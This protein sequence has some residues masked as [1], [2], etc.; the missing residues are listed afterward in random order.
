MKSV[1]T[2]RV[3]LVFSD[4]SQ[5]T[6]T[7]KNGKL[8]SKQRQRLSAKEEAGLTLVN[9][10]R[11]ENMQEINELATEMGLPVVF[12]A[13]EAAQENVIGKIGLFRWKRSGNVVLNHIV[14][15]TSKTYMTRPYGSDEV[16]CP[17]P[18][19]SKKAYFVRTVEEFEIPEILNTEAKLVMGPKTMT[20]TLAKFDMAETEVASLNQAA[21]A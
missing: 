6:W 20:A 21:V 10:F 17:K 19:Y 12:K 3:V 5:N 18:N 16:S 13:E 15:E 14:D 4:E 1:E 9:V 7:I 2:I 11:A 8:D